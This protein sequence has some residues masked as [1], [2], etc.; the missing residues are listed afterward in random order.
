METIITAIIDKLASDIPE[1]R[2]IDI[3]IGQMAVPDPPVDYPCAL[4]DV[5]EIDWTTL[6]C[7]RQRG[8]VNIEIELFFIIRTSTQS[9][10]PKEVRASALEHFSIIKKVYKTLQGLSGD[11]F[12]GLT[13][14]KS[15]RN[16]E[17]YPRGFKMAFTCSIEDSSAV[18]TYRKLS[19]VQLDIDINRG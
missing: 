17:Y 16:K 3:N 13:R 15:Q 9:A 7:K 8:E 1:L 10:A 2:H 19:D 12:S 14:V 18:Q 6:G 11:T 4:I 5:S